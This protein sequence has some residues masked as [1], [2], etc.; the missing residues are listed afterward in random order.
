MVPE[1]RG[2]VIRSR[3]NDLRRAAKWNWFR[4]DEL[5][6]EQ[7]WA[8]PPISKLR[9]SQGD[10]NGPEEPEGMLQGKGSQ[11]LVTSV[12]EKGQLNRYPDGS[13]PPQNLPLL[14]GRA[15]LSSRV[16]KQACAECLLAM[17]EVKGESLSRI[18]CANCR[19]AHEQLTP[20]ASPDP[21]EC[22]GALFGFRCPSCGR[23]CWTRTGLERHRLMHGPWER[24]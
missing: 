2:G 21:R 9:R 13:L 5:Q 4:T 22:Y 1:E 14:P 3:R 15:S 18:A 6:D 8:P 12:T 16:Q 19:H 20:A 11:G 24:N 7:A 10:R 17:E 23:F